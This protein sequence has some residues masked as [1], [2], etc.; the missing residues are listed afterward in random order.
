[1]ARFA[2][3]LDHDDWRTFKRKF[4]VLAKS[5]KCRHSVKVFLS[6]PARIIVE[7]F[8]GQAK[9]TGKV[10]NISPRGKRK[11]GQRH[12]LRIVRVLRF[13]IQAASSRGQYERQWLRS[14]LEE[15]GKNVLM[16][17]ESRN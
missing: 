13:P 10:T 17:S 11:K 7:T 8:Q 12:H 4:Y 2:G 6:Q 1:L 16:V 5:T 3:P 14:F 15:K 9:F